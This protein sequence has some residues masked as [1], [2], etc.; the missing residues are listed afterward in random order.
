MSTF[1]HMLMIRYKDGITDGE[2]DDLLAG[3]ARMPQLMGYIKRYE[4]GHDLGNLGPGTPDLGL[5]ADFE[6]E[7]DWRRYSEDPGHA[8]LAEL[9]RGVSAELIRV[10]YLID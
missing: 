2:K 1:R 5:V 3:F 7:E 9:V 8:A 10:Q 6:S 4:F